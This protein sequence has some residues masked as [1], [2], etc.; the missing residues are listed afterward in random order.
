MIDHVITLTNGV[1]LFPDHVAL[2]SRRRNLF[3]DHVTEFADHV[4]LLTNDVELLLTEDMGDC[5]CAAAVT[6]VGSGIVGPVVWG[7]TIV[8][9]A[10]GRVLGWGVLVIVRRGIRWS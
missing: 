6:R 9:L 5:F 1:T 4:I 7:G 3:A 8:H 2:L 10:D